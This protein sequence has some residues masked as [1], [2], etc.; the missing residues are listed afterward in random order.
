MKT[1]IEHPGESYTLTAIRTERRKRG[2]LHGVAVWLVCRYATELVAE[3]K[4]LLEAAKNIGE[5][6]RSARAE[7]E[8]WRQRCFS[9][10]N[11]LRASKRGIQ[12]EMEK[13]DNTHGTTLHRS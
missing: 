9:A 5:K 1:Y 10:E 4:D 13:H 7:C 11:A 12:M 3:R 2:W 6:L 8:E